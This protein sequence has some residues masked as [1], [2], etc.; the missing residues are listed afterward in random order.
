MQGNDGFDRF[1]AGGLELL[2]LEADEAERAVMAAVDAI[3][4]PHVAALL[5]ADLDDIEP[6]P[7][8]DLSKPPR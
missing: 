7:R 1:A 8:I 4:R 6:E 3:Y 2:G 5:E